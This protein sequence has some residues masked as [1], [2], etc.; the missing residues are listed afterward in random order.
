MASGRRAQR[1]AQVHGRPRPSEPMCRSFPPR[2]RVRGAHPPATEGDLERGSVRVPG[3]A[4]LRPLRDPGQPGRHRGDGRRGRDPGRGRRLPRRRQGP[5]AGRRPRQGGR[6]QARQRR[7]RGA[8]ARREHPRD[9]HQGPHRGAGLGRARLGHRRGVL[10]QLHARPG[11]QAAP[12]DAVGAGR[13]GDRG[14]RRDRPRRHRQA[15]HRPGRRAVRGDGPAGRRPTP[16]SRTRRST[17]SPRSS[18]S[19]TTASRRATATS[20]RSTR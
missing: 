9:G 1:R 10:R 13:R 7:R 5:G 4:V 2:P 16:R 8:H 6:H 17:A 18:S 20:P 12:P 15:A 14:G 3:Q 11:R 19:S